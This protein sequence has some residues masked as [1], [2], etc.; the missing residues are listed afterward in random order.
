MPPKKNLIYTAEAA[1][2]I[3]IRKATLLRWLKDRKIPE[4][5]RDVRGWRV[6]SEKEV[7][8]IQEYAHRINPPSPDGIT[9]ERKS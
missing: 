4:V 1:K 5:S 3:G 7:R 9:D 6:F 8:R 2:R